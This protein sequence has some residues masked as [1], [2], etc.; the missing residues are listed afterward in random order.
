MWG[1]YNLTRFIYFPKI[2][3]SKLTPKKK[4]QFQQ[5]LPNIKKVQTWT[6]FF[7]T[8]LS[9]LSNTHTLPLE[10]FEPKELWPDF[11]GEWRKCSQIEFLGMEETIPEFLVSSEWRNCMELRP[12]P[13]RIPCFSFPFFTKR[14]E[15][16]FTKN[17]QNIVIL[18]DFG[19][20][21]LFCFFLL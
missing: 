8:L 3:N 6:T 1:R 9:T 18:C 14:C 2:T 11:W 17:H 19:L 15:A 10:D 5:A 16:S 20:E 7:W 4:T 13:L 21:L 12:D